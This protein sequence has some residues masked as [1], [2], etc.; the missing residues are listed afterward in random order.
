[1]DGWRLLCVNRFCPFLKIILRSPE[2]ARCRVGIS[3]PDLTNLSYISKHS[4]TD[5]PVLRALM[6]YVN[7]HD[8]ISCI[9]FPV[10]FLDTPEVSS[11][12]R[13]SLM[14]KKSLK[15]EWRGRRPSWQRLQIRV[16]NGGVFTAL[17]RKADRGHFGVA[18]LCCLW[19]RCWRICFR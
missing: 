12:T 1:M 5:N 14:F 9:S 13:V 7:L 6:A 15:T 2:T 4:R 18:N 19:L 8:S 16:F 3:P 10:V 17:K 11:Q